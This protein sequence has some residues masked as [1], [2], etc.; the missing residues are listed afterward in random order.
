MKISVYQQG[1]EGEP[2]MVLERE[3]ESALDAAGSLKDRVFD[4]V[5]SNVLFGYYP[6]GFGSTMKELPSRNEGEVRYTI[7]CSGRNVRITYK[8]DGTISGMEDSSVPDRV[9]EVVVQK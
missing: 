3:D 4:F 7:S 8:D 1:K 9:F 2:Q 5:A 6:Q